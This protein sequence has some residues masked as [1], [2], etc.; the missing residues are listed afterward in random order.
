ML[1]FR[2]KVG[3]VSPH[4]LR[5][6]AVLTLVRQFLESLSKFTAFRLFRLFTECCPKLCKPFIDDLDLCQ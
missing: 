6:G 4:E 2:P 5:V 3:G 1:G